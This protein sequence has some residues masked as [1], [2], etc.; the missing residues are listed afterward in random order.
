MQHSQ[1]I[2]KKPEF[3]AQFDLLSRLP[4]TKNFRKN[5]ASLTFQ[6]LRYSNFMPSFNEAFSRKARRGRTYVLVGPNL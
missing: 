4:K 6:V 1:D 2:F 5:S 3:W